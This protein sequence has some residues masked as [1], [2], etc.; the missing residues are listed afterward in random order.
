[1]LFEVW[2]NK[3]L[4]TERLLVKLYS[5]TCSCYAKFKKLTSNRGREIKQTSGTRNVD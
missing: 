1:M 4:E 2:E 5:V 3:L